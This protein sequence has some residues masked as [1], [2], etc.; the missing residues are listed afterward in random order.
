MERV[1]TFPHKRPQRAPEDCGAII[2]I[3]RAHKCLGLRG[4]SRPPRWIYVGGD[5]DC[6]SVREF[7][8][9]RVTRTRLIKG[10]PDKD[11]ES[12]GESEDPRAT[13]TRSEGVGK[14]CKRRQEWIL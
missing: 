8:G 9:A 14:M 5:K 10:E 12:R 6:V 13:R 4:A 2:S 3:E 7:V 1:Y 11:Q